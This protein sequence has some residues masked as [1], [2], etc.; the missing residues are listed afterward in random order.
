[1]VWKILGCLFVVCSALLAPAACTGPPESLEITPPEV[2]WDTEDGEEGEA[3]ELP[4]EG[5]TETE[6]EVEPESDT[7]VTR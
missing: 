6:S 3:E 7:G 5:D 4:D 1:M 2:A